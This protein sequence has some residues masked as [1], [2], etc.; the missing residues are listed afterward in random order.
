MAQLHHLVV[1]DTENPEA[2]LTAMVQAKAKVGRH[3]VNAMTVAFRGGRGRKW[4]ADEGHRVLCNRPWIRGWEKFY[5]W[6][7]GGRVALRGGRHRR[8]CAD[9]GNRI[10]CNR[11]WIRGWEKFVAV[12]AGGNNVALRGGRGNKYCADDH[13]GVRCNRPW[14]RGWEKFYAHRLSS[15]I[16]E[17]RGKAAHRERVAKGHERRGKGERR[18]KHLRRVAHERR[19]KHQRRSGALKNGLT[20][21]FRGGRGCK[22]CADEGHRVLCNR[23]WIRGWEKFYIW[24]SGGRVAL[25]GR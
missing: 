12:R 20:V 10:R 9:E 17:R 13:H 18:G 21:A 7:S 6:S 23:P 8:W 11:P 2:P 24:S 25:R 5:I 14:I 22:W 1:E 16:H 15:N 4:C 3:L 19:V